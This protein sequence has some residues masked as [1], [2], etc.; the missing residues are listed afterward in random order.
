[1]LGGIAGYAWTVETVINKRTNR[2]I[3]NIK[4]V[5]NIRLIKEKMVKTLIT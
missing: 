4:R 1:M 3:T 2:P 5:N